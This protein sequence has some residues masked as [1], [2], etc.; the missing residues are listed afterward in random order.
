MSADL[1][2]LVLAGGL[3]AEREVSLAS[4]RRVVAALHEA[5]V[6][7]VAVDAGSDLVAVLDDRRPDVVWPVLHGA[8]GEDGSLLQVLELLGL[9]VVGSSATAARLA[10]DKT[11]A[12]AVVER[13]GVNVP[14]SITLAH[15]VLRD[16]GA[17]A[18]LPLVVRTLPGPVVV[19]PVHG[20]SSLGVTVVTDQDQLPRAMMTALG[21]DEACRVE[22]L[23]LG[24]EV[25]VGVVDDGAGPRALPPVEIAPD[26]GSY[27]Y[28]SRYTAGATEFHCPARLP[29]GVL[30]RL[31]AESVGVHRELGLAS[32]S[33]SD[34]IVTPDG[35]PWF[36]EVNTSPG[37]TGTSLLPQAA[38]AGGEALAA[39]YR[40]LAHAALDR[41]RS[42]A[43]AMF[44][45]KPSSA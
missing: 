21:H 4:G 6:H 39:L 19:K 33:R 5:G 14:A 1:D 29:R 40:H 45:V 31:T 41:T 12:A 15:S 20:G 2:V 8:G 44:H 30:D 34:W 23:I 43:A 22:R 17:D 16:L 13:T 3:S 9:P 37:L 42:T 18:V 26:S 27:D 32:L 38:V 28:E 24:V 25:A 36:L 7:A 10:W 35:T 11:S